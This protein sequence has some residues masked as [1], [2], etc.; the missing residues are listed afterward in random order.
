MKGEDL[1]ETIARAL[2]PKYRRLDWCTNA[3]ILLENGNFLQLLDTLGA[4]SS[5]QA[6]LSMSLQQHE[7]GLEACPP[8][9]PGN[10]VAGVPEN[11]NL[12]FG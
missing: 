11:C 12:E 9:R 1:Q 2:Q 4:P 3:Q 7:I 8:R 5:R 6:R 10:P